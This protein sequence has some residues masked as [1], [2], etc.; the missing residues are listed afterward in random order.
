VKL[1]FLKSFLFGYCCFCC[2]PYPFSSLERQ[3][4]FH[5]VL[6]I[7]LNVSIVSILFKAS[8]FSMKQPIYIVFMITQW[9]FTIHFLIIVKEIRVD[10]VHKPWSLCHCL[11]QKHKRRTS[12]PV[13]KSS[14]RP[15]V[16]KWQMEK[17]KNLEKWPESVDKP[18][19]IFF[20]YASLSTNELNKYNL[21]LSWRSSM[22]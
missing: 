7:F 2:I 22:Q 10:S 16:S 18:V 1:T 21:P 14:S 13:N 20:S 15:L 19:F 5:F 6:Q 17:L 9:S 4:L 12:Y 11:L 8:V 3:K